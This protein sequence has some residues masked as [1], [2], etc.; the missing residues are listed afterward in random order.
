[1]RIVMMEPL[2]VSE[3][4]VRALASLLLNMGHEFIYCEDKLENDEEL[5]SRLSSADVIILSNQ[6]LS[7]AVIN[8]CPNLKLISTAFTGV[9]HIDIKLCKE[10]GINVRNAAGYSTHSVAEL[11]FG[12]M[13]DIMRKIIPCDVAVREGKTR[14]GFIGNELYGK[15]L[16]IIGT[17]AI[18]MKVA[19]IGKAFGC[20]LLAYSRTEKQYGKIL[21]VE[22]VTLEE[23][24][25]KSDIVTLHVPLNDATRGIINK[26]K[27]DLMKPSSILINTARGPVVDNAALSEALKAGKIAGAGIDVFE[28]EP[29]IHREHP[30]F[31]APNT[32]LTPH[33][34]FATHEA[35]Y[36][37]TEIGFDNIISWING[38]EKNIVV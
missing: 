3:Q 2:G 12:L 27:I 20:K 24:M 18:G 25:C 1:M 26:D 6:K 9:D 29:P 19:E 38:I 16:G 30:L 5:I 4:E 35:I 7:G 10:K 23:L 15:T 8:A 21:G 37:K 14:T 11:A 36:K 17:G 13:I 31:N 33:V 32:V 22:Y 28:M 34:A